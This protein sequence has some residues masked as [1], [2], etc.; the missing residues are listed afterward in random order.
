MTLSIVTSGRNDLHAGDF[1][2]RMNRSFE[3]LP[4]DAE[5]IM[6]EWN[7]PEDRPALASMIRR[8][9]VR[10]ITVSRELHNQMHGH[11][12]LPFFE[13]RAKNVGIRRAHGNWILSMNPDIILGQ[14]ML[15]RLGYDFDHHCCYVAPRH[16]IEGGK[17]VRITSGPGD[18]VLMHRDKWSDLRGYLDIV[19]YSHIDSL[20]LWNAESIG[21]PMV[22]L[23]CPIFHQEHDRSV[24]KGRM[25]IH[26]SDLHWFVGQKNDLD[27]GFAKLD[28]AETLT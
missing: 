1:I 11:D 25:S 13:Y 21:I 27:W 22:E 10:V 4:S 24:H 28:L 12:L 19:S 8:N 26:S 23:P 18:F 15:E 16:D 7:P 2:D 3:T 17:L 5:I 9:G 20:L 6:V 14:E